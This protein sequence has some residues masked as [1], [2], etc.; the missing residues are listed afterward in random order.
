[1]KIPVI[2]RAECTDCEGCM[3]MAPTVF[4]KNDSGIIEV[5]P[6]DAY[7]EDEVDEAIK[8]CPCKC[9]RWEDES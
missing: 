8:N 2:D 6:L 9:I 5:L 3:A 7:P 4:I 1:M